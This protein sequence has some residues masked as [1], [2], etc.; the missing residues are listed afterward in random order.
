MVEVGSRTGYLGPEPLDELTGLTSRAKRHERLAGLPGMASIH[1]LQTDASCQGML[2]MLWEMQNILGE[3]A[4]LEH[5]SLQ[6]AAGAQGEL[7]ALLVAAA[8]FRD[9]K[10]T[11]SRVLIPDS[12]HG[13]NPASAAIAGF[14][15]VSIKSNERGLV[16]MNDLKAKL[17]DRLRRIQSASVAGLLPRARRPYPKV[18]PKYQNPKNPAETWSGRGKPPL[19][20]KEQLRAGKKL[21]RFLIDQPHRRSR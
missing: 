9:R 19:W 8:Y 10:E 20:V 6:P 21:D 4:G 18:F 17:D 14:E 12:A 3:I 7:S 1:P 11:R 13:T 2:A 16:D 5:V 15:A